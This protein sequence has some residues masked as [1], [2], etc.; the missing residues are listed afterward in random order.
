ME[1]RNNEHRNVD[2]KQGDFLEEPIQPSQIA[3]LPETLDTSPEPDL[4][5]DAL[6]ADPELPEQENR[7]LASESTPD[8]ADDEQVLLMVTCMESWIVTDR[9]TLRS[10]YGSKLQASALPALD[11]METRDRDSIQQA[12]S[13]A[14]RNCK[15]AYTKGKRS[16]EVV[17]ALDPSALRPHL[18][19]FVRCERVLAEK[20]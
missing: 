13:H 11:N 17:A 12:L 6:E 5:D 10:H 14:T 9:K 2:G 3:S 16:F 18:P 7:T 8:G 1:Q 15:N 20:L 19:S 4:P